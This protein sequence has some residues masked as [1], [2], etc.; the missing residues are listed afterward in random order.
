MRRMKLAQTLKAATMASVLAAVSLT[1]G[2]GEAF[3]GVPTTAAIAPAVTASAEGI[4]AQPVYWRHYGWHGYGW[5]RG[6]HHG[7]G[8][9][10]GYAWGGPVV[11]G[12]CW[13]WRATP[14][15]PRR[16]WVC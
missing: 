10:P 14:W 7:W 8:W 5:H 3:A 9:G 2:V 11:Y 6:W 15:G 13:R 4:A 16:V 1:N 12:G